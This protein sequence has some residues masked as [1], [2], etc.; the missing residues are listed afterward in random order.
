MAGIS[1]ANDT[2]GPRLDKAGLLQAILYRLEA[3]WATQ[4][5]AA[6]SSRAEA[7]DP[8][9]RAEGKFD[10]RGQSAGY[11]AAGQGKLAA[12]IAE[13]LAAYRALVP[14]LFQPGEAIAVGA[15]A[16]VEAGGEHRRFFIG[17][18]R[19]GLELEIDGVPVTVIT[20]ASTL[21]RS[22]LG[23]RAGE[24]VLAATGQPRVIAVE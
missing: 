6:E 19:G 21:G 14:R 10:M 7:T 2:L 3:E 23:R 4:A 20:G 11:L 12:E 22:L 16:T 13:A 15:I 9:S 1:S 24:T 17:P 5:A 18:S 8:D